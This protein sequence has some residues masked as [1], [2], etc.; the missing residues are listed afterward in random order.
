MHGNGGESGNWVSH[1]II[2]IAVILVLIGAG[3]SLYALVKGY[4][5]RS[6]KDV[7]NAQRAEHLIYTAIFFG[8]LAIYSCQCSGGIFG[9]GMNGSC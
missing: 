3:F 2:A 7:H 9:M 4:D 6:A 5:K 1:L 8:I